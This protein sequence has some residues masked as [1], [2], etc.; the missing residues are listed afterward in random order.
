MNFKKSL[1][2]L[3]FLSI[4]AFAFA[5]AP[6]AF[7][8]YDESEA[9]SC[10]SI[11]VG[12]KASTDGSVMTAHTCDSNYR[13]WLN[14]TKRKKYSA[15]QTQPIYWG[16]LHTEEPHDPRN[17]VEKGRIPAFDGETYSFLNVAYPCMNE[18]QLAMGETTTV[19]KRELRDTNGL[20]LIEE[21]ERIALERCTTAREAIKLIGALAEEYGFGDSG[22]CL[23]I[24][25]KNEVWHF[26]IYGTNMPKK[27]EPAEKGKKKK[28]SKFDKP[29]ALWAA[30]RIP[31]DHVGVSANIPRIGVIDFNDPDNFMYASDLKER[32]QHMGLWDGKSEFKFYKMVSNEKN[33][34]VREF[35]IFRTLAPS[36]GLTYDMEE[37]PFSIKPE[38]K[39]SPE[40]MFALYRQTYE[41]TE[42]DQVKNL[43]VEVDRREKQSNGTYKEWKE[44]V[45]PV[46]PFMP[47]DMRA[48]FNKIEKDVAPRVRTVA[49]IQ[50]SYSHII[51]LR[52]WL[53]D[54]IGG[55]AYFAFDNPAQSPRIPIYCGETSL[56]KGFEV[57][58]QSRYREDAA[59]WSYRE[60]NRIA[61]ISWNKTRHLIEPM[62]LDYEK[63]MMEQC[64]AVEEQ[65]AKLIKEGKKDEA[66]KMLNEFTRRFEASTRNSWEELKADLWTIFARAM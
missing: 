26:E 19:G 1:F 32:T 17:L 50:C 7:N 54:E 22:E 51:Q 31:D 66:V 48:L 11:M 21:L 16:A 65:A 8:P 57:C 60:T 6:Y 45:C 25:D 12:K 49:V 39:V 13:T 63:A 2:T 23:T 10:T 62:V 28:P 43:Y 56:P 35:F 61:T 58:G 37:L 47:N 5:Q 59:I 4:A 53:P 9:E 55:V 29:G 40:T 24:A 14:M 3:A 18:K 42:F 44:T 41:G 20:F 38:K 64:K 52:D 15:N 27:D 34:S 30:Q 46:S 33:F 36:L